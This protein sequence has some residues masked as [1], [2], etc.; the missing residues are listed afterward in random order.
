MI[1]LFV[2]QSRCLYIYLTKGEPCGLRIQKPPPK[3]SIFS[4]VS[5]SAGNLICKVVCESLVV[6]ASGVDVRSVMSSHAGWERSLWRKK[7]VKERVWG[8]EGWGTERERERE[9]V[10][11]LHARIPHFIAAWT[12]L[13]DVGGGG[14]VWGGCWNP[15][16]SRHLEPIQVASWSCWS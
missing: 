16:S 7:R 9:G 12:S 2:T 15:T 10:R 14:I 6:Q 11:L 3:N 13:C 5:K 8:R 4:P 1:V